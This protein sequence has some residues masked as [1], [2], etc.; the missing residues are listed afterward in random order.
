MT[1]INATWTDC[2][3]TRGKTAVKYMTN[4]IR[5]YVGGTTAKV[6]GQRVDLT[7]YKCFSAAHSPVKI[8]QVADDPNEIIALLDS[9]AFTDPPAKRLTP[10]QALDRQIAW[11]ERFSEM[12]GKTWKA[13][14]F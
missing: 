1:P 3:P 4:G 6:K 11:E 7:G 8:G 5:L 12:T 9:G 14:L 2:G 10:G 13:E